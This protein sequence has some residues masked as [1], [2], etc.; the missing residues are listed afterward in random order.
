MVQKLLKQKLPVASTFR[1]ELTRIIMSTLGP[2]RKSYESYS[3]NMIAVNNIRISTNIREVPF[4][5]SQSQ[6]TKRNIGSQS[7]SRRTSQIQG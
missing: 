3:R 7:L 4:E 1:G 5:N 6:G 2:I